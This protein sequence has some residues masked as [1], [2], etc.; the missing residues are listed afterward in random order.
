[1]PTTEDTI[2]AVGGAIEAAAGEGAE[3]GAEALALSEMQDVPAEDDDSAD[4]AGDDAGEGD[5]ADEED[6]E[7]D[8]EDDEDEDEQGPEIACTSTM[9]GTPSKRINSTSTTE[10]ASLKEVCMEELPFSWN[11]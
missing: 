3:T 8:D 7:E 11:L 1:M 4:D 6:E 5:E 10:S 2:G 9:A